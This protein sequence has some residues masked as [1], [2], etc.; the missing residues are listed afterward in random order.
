MDSLN[1]KLGGYFEPEMASL[2]GPVMS[3]DGAK[4]D[5]GLSQPPRWATVRFELRML[6][7]RMNTARYPANTIILPPSATLNCYFINQPQKNGKQNRLW[8]DL[9]LQ[10]KETE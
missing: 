8:C 3:G 2:K 10:C 6:R 9:N 7:A 1:I 4:S 5:E